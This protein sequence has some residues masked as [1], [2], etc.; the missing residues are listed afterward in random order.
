MKEPLQIINIGLDGFVTFMVLNIGACQMH[1]NPHALIIFRQDKRV[2]RAFK[3]PAAIDM[4][5]GII[6]VKKTA[7]MVPAI[8]DGF[9]IRV[10]VGE[11]HACRLTDHRLLCF[12]KLRPP[13]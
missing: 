7:K 5:G 8:L 9:D 4:A 12:P 6:F 13:G 3:R 1:V 10:I 2:K 11:I